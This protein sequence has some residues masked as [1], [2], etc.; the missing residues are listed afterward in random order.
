LIITIGYTGLRWGETIGLELGYVHPAEI[1]VEWQL[2]ELKG[3][4]HR[5]PPKD[6]SYRTTNG[7]P[8]SVEVLG[9]PRLPIV[10]ID[11]AASP[12]PRRG[13]RVGALLGGVGLESE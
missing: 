7:S 13:V 1:H 9:F 8:L 6:D 3:K 5:L 2:H 4:F 10:S 12:D 11:H